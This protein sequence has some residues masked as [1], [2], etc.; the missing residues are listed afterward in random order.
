MLFLLTPSIPVSLS[1]S[2]RGIIT[3][4][5]GSLTG[6]ELRRRGV[7]ALGS[8]HHRRGWLAGWLCKSH[9]AGPA[10]AALSPAAVAVAAM[11]KN[12]QLKQHHTHPHNEEW[13]TV[14]GTRA[15]SFPELVEK[16]S[17]SRTAAWDCPETPA[18]QLGP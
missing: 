1:L 5:K 14:K 10:M 17:Q 16:A 13:L 7:A 8:Q 11:S 18:P 4:H 3:R 15:R 2:L 6:V 9:W 12:T